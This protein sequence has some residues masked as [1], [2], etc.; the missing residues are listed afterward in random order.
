MVGQTLVVCTAGNPVT[1][2]GSLPEHMTTA[3]VPNF[4]PCTSRG[5]ILSHASGVY[6]V[7]PNGL[8]ICGQGGAIN[9]TKDL[10]TRDKWRLV[11]W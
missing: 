4:E 10:L 3:K 1:V 9:V 11:C 7:S 2:N 8:I 6:F 5:S